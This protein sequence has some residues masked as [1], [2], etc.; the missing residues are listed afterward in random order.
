[1]ITAAVIVIAAFVLIGGN[2]IFGTI[3]DILDET[4]ARKAKRNNRR[5]VRK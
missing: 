3:T 4:K 5:H 1:M 2:A